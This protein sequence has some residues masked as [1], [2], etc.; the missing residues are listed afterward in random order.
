MVIQ[1][2]EKHACIIGKDLTDEFSILTKSNSL[3]GGKIVDK[4]VVVD[5]APV[6]L[7]PSTSFDQYIHAMRLV[8]S[9]G[10]PSHMQADKFLKDIVKDQNIRSFLLTNFQYDSNDK[11]LRLKLN[12]EEIAENMKEIWDFPFAR[13]GL[14]MFDKPTLFLNGGK[15]DYLTP[16]MYPGIRRLFPQMSVQTVENAGHWVSSFSHTFLIMLIN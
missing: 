12:L 3:G 7:K 5:I 14:T 1:W 4:L 16:D 8:E 6:A 2:E 13:T 11:V 15:S 10:I 9:E